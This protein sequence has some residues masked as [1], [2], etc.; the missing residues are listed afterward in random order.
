[1]ADEIDFEA[2]HAKRAERHSIDEQ[3][4]QKWLVEQAVKA[5]H[6]ARWMIVRDR[7]RNQI[8]RGHN[9]TKEDM[10]AALNNP[11]RPPVDAMKVRALQQAKARI[12]SAT[13]ARIPPDPKD[14]FLVMDEE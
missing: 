4:R 11:D 12:R 1:M 13:I 7:V 8:A 5:T 14:I 3:K 9:P 2:I 6:R 10:E